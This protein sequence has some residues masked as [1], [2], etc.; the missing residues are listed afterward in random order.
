MFKR[1]YTGF[2]SFLLMTISA[3]GLAYN[4]D[5]LDDMQQVLQGM[6]GSMYKVSSMGSNDPSG[7]AFYSSYVD[8]LRLLSNQVNE[9]LL[10]RNQGDFGKASG[11]LSGACYKLSSLLKDINYD[12]DHAAISY[13]VRAQMQLLRNDVD[14]VMLGIDCAEAPADNS[15]TVPVVPVE[16][17]V[18]HVEPFPSAPMPVHYVEYAYPLTI[19]APA[20]FSAYSSFSIV[21][22]SALQYP[23]TAEIY[24][25]EDG[26]IYNA[27][28][29]TRFTLN[30][31]R[32]Y[33]TVNFHTYPEPG[34]S[35]R[36]EVRKIENSFSTEMFSRQVSIQ[37]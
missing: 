21:I 16:A 10:A 35:Y 28:A 1:F 18:S 8:R 17:A 22:T 4:W 7:V 15:A 23:V 34:K 11:I 12:L 37:Y 3:Q 27:Y 31:G 36:L 26:G 29:E 33:Q 24:V 20:T 25:K 30:P 2:L 13:E 9:A 32:N 19:E 6:S 5:N 14:T